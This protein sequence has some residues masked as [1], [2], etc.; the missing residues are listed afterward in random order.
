MQ[1]LT[2]R[3]IVTELDKYIVGQAAAKRAVAVA[4]RNRV[5][6]QLVPEEMRDEIT[7]KNI[8]L[9]GRHHSQLFFRLQ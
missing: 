6:R 7:P 2:P 9:I 8:M 3:Q 5:R 1:D 4:L